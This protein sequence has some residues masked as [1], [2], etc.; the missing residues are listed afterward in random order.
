MSVQNHKATLDECLDASILMNR[1]MIT[2]VFIADKN[3]SILA[4]KRAPE[5]RAALDRSYL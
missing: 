1:N 4:G 2:C 5:D 3:G